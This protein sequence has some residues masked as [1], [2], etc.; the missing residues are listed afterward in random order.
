MLRFC[1]RFSLLHFLF[2]AQAT[3]CDQGLGVGEH[4]AC[5]LADMQVLVE[6]DLLSTVGVVKADTVV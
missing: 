5:E 4:G 1:D 6:S 2:A 3:S